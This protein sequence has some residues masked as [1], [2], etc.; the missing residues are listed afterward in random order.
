[1]WEGSVMKFLLLIG[2]LEFFGDLFI[3]LYGKE[4]IFIFKRIGDKIRLK[5]IMEIMVE[6]NEVVIIWFN[7]EFVMKE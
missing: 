2:I 6:E 1:M 3:Y 5:K 7:V 4:Y